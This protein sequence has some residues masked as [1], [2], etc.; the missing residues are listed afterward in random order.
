[1][2]RSIC[3]YE[4]G[5]KRSGIAGVGPAFAVRGRPVKTDPSPSWL[6]PFGATRAANAGPKPDG[7]LRSPPIYHKSTE[8]IRMCQREIPKRIF[9]A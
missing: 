1:V 4:K 5:A 7:Y 9:P 3:R 6:I 8:N 2:T